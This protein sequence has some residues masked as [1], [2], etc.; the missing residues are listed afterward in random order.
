MGAVL[1]CHTGFSSG[2][3]GS[4]CKVSKRLCWILSC[5]SADSW[6]LV[7]VRIVSQTPSAYQVVGCCSFLFML[8]ARKETKAVSHVLVLRVL[9]GR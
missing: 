3:K 7:Y 2:F 4:P 6:R 1:G 8:P 9:P 5:T